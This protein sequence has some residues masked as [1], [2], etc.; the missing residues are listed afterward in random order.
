MQSY[1]A[2]VRA[3]VR[4]VAMALQEGRGEQ[5]A[6]ELAIAQAQPL[7]DRAHSA[8]ARLR[9]TAPDLRDVAEARV[10]MARVQSRNP[11]IRM[12]SRIE[13]D[14]PVRA[15]DILDRHREV[16]QN[17]DLCDA[18]NLEIKNR[19]ELYLR[20]AQDLL[21]RSE[22]SHG[23]RSRLQLVVG[24]SGIARGGDQLEL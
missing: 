21:S 7:W 10:V 17:T 23:N 13:Q 2:Q 22:M 9:A 12:I 3:D 6:R 20:D 15:R 16:T 5:V 24:R 4:E 14:D 1:Q 19:A 18:L 8:A 11:L